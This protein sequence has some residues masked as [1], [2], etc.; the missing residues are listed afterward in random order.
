MAIDGITKAMQGLTTV[1]EVFRVAPPEARGSVEE[2]VEEPPAQGW[3][4]P[5]DPSVFE[6]KASVVSTSPKKILVVDDNAVILKLLRHLLEAED[7]LVVTAEN[8]LEG[9]KTASMER[10]SLIITDFLMPKIQSTFSGSR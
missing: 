3:A 10:P 2:P 8:G 5:E 1:D 6:P 9:L 4:A 7:Y